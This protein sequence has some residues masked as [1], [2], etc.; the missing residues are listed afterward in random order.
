[1]YNYEKF[2]DHFVIKEDDKI[3]C[4][5]DTEAE[6]KQIVF[7]LKSENIDFN[8][9][10]IKTLNNK[11]YITYHLHTEDSLLD[12]CTNDKYYHVQ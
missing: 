5:I 1:M 4:H 10:N 7:S 3:L 8:K 6:A 12:S 11:N 2:Y 9:E